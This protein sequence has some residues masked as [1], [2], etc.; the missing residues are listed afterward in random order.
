MQKTRKKS[1]TPRSFA[2]RLTRRAQPGNDRVLPR[3]KPVGY[4]SAVR[5]EH[6]CLWQ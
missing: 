3:N 4:V 5:W 1:R 6:Y 2:E